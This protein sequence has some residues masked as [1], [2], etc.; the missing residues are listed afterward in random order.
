MKMAMY[1]LK[2]E[3]TR[4]VLLVVELRWMLEACKRWFL[5]GNDNGELAKIEEQEAENLKKRRLESLDTVASDYK[6]RPGKKKR[7]ENTS[8]IDQ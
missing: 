5:P 4:L 6:G 3:E 7:K 1:T 8:N 2:V